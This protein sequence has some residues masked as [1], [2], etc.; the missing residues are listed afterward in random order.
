MVPQGAMAPFDIAEV[1]ISALVGG[2]FIFPDDT[3][4]V[5]A[6]YAISISKPLL[7]PVKVEIQHCVSIEG[8]AHTMCLSFASAPS[9]LL[10]YNFQLVDGGTFSIGDRYGS[11]FLSK[12]SLWSIIKNI[13]FRRQ[14]HGTEATFQNTSEVNQSI[15][16]SST[17][18]PVSPAARS[19]SFRDVSV[20]T[21][22]TNTMQCAT[23]DFLPR[24]IVTTTYAS[25]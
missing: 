19:V 23:C 4:L 6:V 18:V 2:D 17:P 3:E 13:L 22:L 20:Q 16:S 9:D 7:K 24:D 14:Y 25:Y 11:I 12:I 1:A 21:L 10:P 8:V 5:S 15:S